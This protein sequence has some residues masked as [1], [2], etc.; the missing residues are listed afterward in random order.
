MPRCR[1]AKYLLDECVSIHFPYS[2]VKS[3]KEGFV[4]SVKKVGRGAKDET[5]S[6]FA[7][8][9][10]LIVVTNDKKFSLNMILE[11]RIIIYQFSD[12]RRIRITPIIEQMDHIAKFHDEVSAYLLKFDEIVVP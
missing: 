6:E 12:G 5:I 9:K 4:E 8:K 7:K 11:N 2:I 10:N 1:K 3:R